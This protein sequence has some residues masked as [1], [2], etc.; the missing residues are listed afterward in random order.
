M[1]SD[2]IIEIFP[3]VAALISAVLAV[4]SFVADRQNAGVA[5]ASGTWPTTA[6]QVRSSEVITHVE[7]QANAYG[8]ETRY[9]TYEAK[10]DYDYGV[11]GVSFS[12]H[13]L[14]F[15]PD[16]YQSEAAARDAIAKFPPGADVVV[17]YDPAA[18]QTSVLDRET[19]AGLSSRTWQ[20][21][22]LAGLFVAVGVYVVYKA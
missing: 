6:G 11:G 2:L 4:R 3:F 17:A 22:V 8:G 10:V 7:T 14:D 15:R 21:L 16:R 1:T 5:T 13:R 12:G 19:K 20:M 18:P 9:V